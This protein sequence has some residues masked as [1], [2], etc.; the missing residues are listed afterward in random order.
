MA[1]MEKPS[2]AVARA[3]VGLGLVNCRGGLPAASLGARV[4]TAVRALLADA[5]GHLLEY[6]L[7][8]WHAIHLGE[9][10]L[11]GR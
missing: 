5:M 11:P 3:W 10:L 1:G 2:R 4:L 8:S 6:A 9:T 7:E